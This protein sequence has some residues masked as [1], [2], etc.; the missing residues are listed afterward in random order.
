MLIVFMLNK[1]KKICKN[2]VTLYI[3]AMLTYNNN[4]RKEYTLDEL[5][6]NVNLQ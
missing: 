1:I 4:S 3:V 5:K 2:I 6:H